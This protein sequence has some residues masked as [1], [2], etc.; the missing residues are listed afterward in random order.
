[1]KWKVQKYPLTTSYSQKLRL[2]KGS[3]ILTAIS[4]NKK[5]SLFALVPDAGTLE[6]WGI[7]VVATSEVVANMDE[8]SCSSYTYLATVDGSHIF[9]WRQFG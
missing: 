9:Y 5:L 2:P 6:E 8:F 1:M 7:K 4:E 3:A